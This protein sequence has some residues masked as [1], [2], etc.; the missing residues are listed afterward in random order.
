MDGKAK[1]RTNM[2][3][4]KVNNLRHEYLNIVKLENSGSTC[5]IVSKICTNVTFLNNFKDTKGIKMAD[6]SLVSLLKTKNP[7]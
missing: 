2:G 5:G 4:L 6:P 3:V 1:S 7:D